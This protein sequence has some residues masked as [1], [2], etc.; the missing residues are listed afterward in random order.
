MLAEQ[1]ARGEHR[2]RT[3]G[4]TNEHNLLTAAMTGQSDVLWEIVS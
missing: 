2:E 4:A 3:F 1:Q